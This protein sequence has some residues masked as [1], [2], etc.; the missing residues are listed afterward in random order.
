MPILI[1]YLATLVPFLILDALMITFVIG[2]LFTANLGPTLAAS[3][4]IIPAVLFYF[5]YPMA[6]LALASIPAM[7]QNTSPFLPAAILGLAA[8]ATYELTS[9]S[10]MAAWTPGM[11]AL[12][13]AWG[14][15]LT[16]ASASIGLAITRRLGQ[17]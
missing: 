17:A 14:T 8:Y 1:L 10:L 6:V 2:P 3:P 16:G 15:V 4:R 9:L 13:M 7:R 5:G 11:A 12:D